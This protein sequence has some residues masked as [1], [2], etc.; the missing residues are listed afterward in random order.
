M[1]PA[2]FFLAFGLA[3]A[4]FYRAINTADSMFGY[5]D[6]PL[7]HF[8]KTAARLDDALNFVPARLAGLSLVVGAALVGESARGALAILRRDH[9]RTQSPNAG[10]TM[11]A[12]AGALGVALE[13]PRAYRLGDGGHPV[14][15]DI[16]RSIS[17]L[18]AA[19][20]LSL[21]LAAGVVVTL[22]RLLAY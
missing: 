16:E 17:V 22:R 1:A 19:A 13:K 5:R 2:C 3:G 12:M 4:A 9:R 18:E 6:G 10:W 20:L 8:G 7:E 15:G 21:L 14:C 11:A